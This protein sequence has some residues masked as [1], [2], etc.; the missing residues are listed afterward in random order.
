[1]GEMSSPIKSQVHRE[2]G[3][4]FYRQT[5]TE[6]LPPVL[7][8]DRLEKAIVCYRRALDTSVNSMEKSSALKNI[9]LSSMKLFTIMLHVGEHKSL[10]DYYLKEGIQNIDLALNQG[11]FGGQTQQWFNALYERYME[12]LDLVFHHLGSKKTKDRCHTL[13]ELAK[14]INNKQA[15]SRILRE[16]ARVY[17]N[18]SVVA[19]EAGDFRLCLSLLGDCHRPLEEAKLCNT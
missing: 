12:I 11:Q 1:A 19:L 15:K 13:E 3:N 16:T 9:A 2:E 7:Q 10:T 17:F 18:G 8:R 4:K 6:G 14:K 5:Q